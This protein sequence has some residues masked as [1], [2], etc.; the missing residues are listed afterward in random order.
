MICNHKRLKEL[1]YI[2]KAE[3][4][5]V[6]KRMRNIFVVKE[7]LC[8][9]QCVS[10]LSFDESSIIIKIYDV[11]ST[12]LTNVNTEAQVILPGKTRVR[13]KMIIWVKKLSVW[14]LLFH[15]P[16]PIPHT[17]AFKRTNTT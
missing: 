1:W 8:S 6:I 4:Y 5:E 16:I 10:I 14:G 17:S 12:S 2:Y 7:E 11:T 13:K 3:Y 15:F 9:N